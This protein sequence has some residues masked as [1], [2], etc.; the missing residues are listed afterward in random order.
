MGILLFLLIHN[1]KPACLTPQLSYSGRCSA[2][3]TLHRKEIF[4]T[5]DRS[6]WHRGFHF[7]RA[8]DKRLS[9]RAQSL[10]CAG[11]VLRFRAVAF[12]ASNRDA[13]TRQGDAALVVAAFSPRH[14]AASSPSHLAI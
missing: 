4:R 11:C 5:P 1:R 9:H 13:K 6:R 8:L 7:S 2:S 3:W 12:V 14:L 10:H